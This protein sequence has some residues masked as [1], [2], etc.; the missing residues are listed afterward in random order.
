MEIE[1]DRER[2]A[3]RTLMERDR[4]SAML[5][6]NSTPIDADIAAA[7]EAG[8]PAA[9]FA[10]NRRGP[11]KNDGGETSGAPFGPG[12]TTANSQDRFGWGRA[13]ERHNARR[14]GAKE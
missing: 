1:T 9:I 4:I 5:K 8:T 12:V 2:M 3:R 14:G 10:T 11:T 13:V 7:I 6:M